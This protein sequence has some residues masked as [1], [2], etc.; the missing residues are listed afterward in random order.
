M[1][2][3]TGGQIMLNPQQAEMHAK[4]TM[5]TLMTTPQF[6]GLNL[7]REGQNVISDNIARMAQQRGQMSA[8]T[9]EMKVLGQLQGILKE[10][11]TVKLPEMTITAGEKPQQAEQASQQ[12]VSTQA[13]RM[14]SAL[15]ATSQQVSRTESNLEHN[16][17]NRLYEVGTGVLQSARA[18]FAI[19]EHPLDTAAGLWQAATGD[20]QAAVTTGGLHHISERLI[21]GGDKMYGENTAKTDQAVQQAGVVRTAE[22]EFRAAI[23]QYEH[24]NGTPGFAASEQKLGQ[25]ATHLNQEIE[26]FNSMTETAQKANQNIR[27]TAIENAVFAIV[28]VPLTIATAGGAKI[29]G[30]AME[31]VVHA[32]ITG[33][34]EAAG[35]A[36][37]HIAETGM[38]KM[39]AVLGTKAATTIATEGAAVAAGVVTTTVAETAAAATGAAIAE[40]ATVAVAK[41]ATTA[42][43]ETIGVAVAKS[44]TSAV[45]V[46]TEKAV[47][48][49]VVGWIGHKVHD[50][51]ELMSE[52]HE[53]ANMSH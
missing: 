16:R 3:G 21:E 10:Q 47:H 15:D 42:A 13:Q 6:S 11:Q 25:A 38:K 26:R 52:G 1:A 7:P 36:A 48:H 8:G 9:V 33:G 30:H 4:E 5:Q 35:Q 44:A 31:H 37:I 29:I 20:A 40:G 12:E 14:R 51:A 32:G 19:A 17:V 23:D 50:G 34:T 41:A 28:E 53:A 46:P 39:A 24:S 45:I 2:E 27:D 18:G 43:T 49:Q 22:R